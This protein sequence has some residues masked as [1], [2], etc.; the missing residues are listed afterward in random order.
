MV[1]RNSDISP[2]C[3]VR[4]KTSKKEKKGS[5]VYQ[6]DGVVRDPAKVD[7]ECALQEGQHYC[8]KAKANNTWDKTAG[9]KQCK[10]S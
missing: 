9:A 6:C 3:A 10:K 4:F 8:P 7:W 1:K 2:Q 5:F